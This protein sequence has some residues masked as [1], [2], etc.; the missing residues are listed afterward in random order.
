VPKWFTFGP[1]LPTR[2]VVIVVVIVVVVV[3][4]VVVIVVVIVVAVVVVAVIIVVVVVNAP[5][6]SPRLLRLVPTHHEPAG[7]Q[8]AFHLRRTHPCGFAHHSQG[9]LFGPHRVC[10]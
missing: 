6:L 5:F 7:R 2:I 4:V 10:L 8:A 9:G 3:V 1:A